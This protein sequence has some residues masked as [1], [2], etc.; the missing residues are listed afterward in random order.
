MNT[1][2]FTLIEAAISITIFSVVAVLL[3]QVL[4]TSVQNQV[5]I[6][7]TQTLL[8]ETGFVL[9]YISKD[10]RMSKRA[11]N[12]N[13]IT[14]GEIAEI[15]TGGIR[16]LSYD[17]EADDYKCKQ[18][19]LNESTIKQQVSSTDSAA[20]FNAE[21]SLSSSSVSVN[22]LIINIEEATDNL[23][24]RISIKIKTENSQIDSGFPVL[25]QTSIAPRN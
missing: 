13:C 20:N 25:V 15:I 18:V 8:N 5:K 23:K 14:E 19:F 24:E 4:V 7:Y 17:S 16:Y 21:V 12:S 10:L 3:G 9:D 11:D 2:A 1:R 6:T 22:E